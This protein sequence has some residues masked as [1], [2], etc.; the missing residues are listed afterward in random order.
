ME[1]SSSIHVTANGIIFMAEYYSV[2]YMFHKFSIHLLNDGHLGCYH[3]LTIVNHAIVNI[4]VQVSLQFIILTR[5]MP[6]RG[7]AGSYGNS[8]LHTVFQSGYTKLYSHQQC[9]R[10]QFPPHPLQNVLFVNFLMKA[11]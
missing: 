10:V 2:V 1:I 7:I 4:G 5:Y 11:I 3:V 8:N 6:G 9:R